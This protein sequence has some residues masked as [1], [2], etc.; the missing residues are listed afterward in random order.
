MWLTEYLWIGA[1]G[2]VTGLHNDD[3][4]NFLLQVKATR[5][6]LPLPAPDA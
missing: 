4:A 6:C 2:S 3:E 1:A 5:S